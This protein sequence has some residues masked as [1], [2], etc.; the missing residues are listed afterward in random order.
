[1]FVKRTLKEF[2]RIDILINNAG[3]P[4]P[5]TFQAIT[6]AQWRESFELNLMSAIRLIHLGLPSMKQQA[7]GRIINM[8]GSSAKQPLE[9]LLLSN[10]FRPAVIDMAKHWLEKLRRII[11]R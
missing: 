4:P 8:T 3:G 7:W 2:G 5:G 11:L 6:E 1:M 10:A 9:N